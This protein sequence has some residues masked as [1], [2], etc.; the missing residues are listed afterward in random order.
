MPKVG[1]W[2]SY[3]YFSR[4]DKTIEMPHKI[5]KI[6]T[7]A[8]G[9]FLTVII[10]VSFL[11][12]CSQPADE[13]TQWNVYGGGPEGIRYS[14]L[15]QIDTNNVAQLQPVWEFHSGDAD[16]VNHSQIQCNPIIIDTVL[17]GTTPQQKLFAINAKTGKELWR[18]DPVENFKKDAGHFILNNTR[19]ICIWQEGNDKRIFFTAGS[20]LHAIDAQTGKLITPF[21]NKGKVDLHEGLGRDVKDLFI[22]YTSPGTIYKNLIIMGSRVSEDADAAPGHIRAY[23]TKTGKQVWIFHTIPQ[24]GEPGFET[25]DD[26]NA[27]KHI[28]GANCWSGFTLDEKRGTVFA[29]TGSAS[30]DFYG[31]MR[32]GANLYADCILALDAATGKL[33]WHYQYVHHDVWDKDLPTPPALVTVKRNGKD[34]DAVA[35]PTKTGTVFVLDRETGKPLF[36]IEER[37]VNTQTELTGEKL[38][39]TQPFPILP[40]PFARQDF[41]DSDVNDLIDTSEQRTIKA[42]LAQLDRGHIFTPPGKRGTVIFPGYD[43][44]AEWGGPAY[45]P[46]TGLLYV[47]ANEMPWILKL[48]D[49]KLPSEHETL[50]DAGK[51]LFT[52]NCMSCHGKNR[53][54][55]G[56]Y[57]SLLNVKDKYTVDQFLTLIQSGRRMMPSFQQLSAEERAAIASFILDIKKDQSKTF[58][59]P[60]AIDTF[61]QLAY[62]GTGYNKFLTKDGWPAIKPPWG[63]LS[64]IDLNSGAIAWKIPLG[65]IAKFKE[66]GII[67]G[68]ENYGGPVVTAGGLVFIAA[69]SDSKI[70]AF[71][72]RTGQL[73][74]EAKLPACGFATPAVYSVEG[75]QYIV[76]ACGGGKLGRA[77]GDSY[78]AFGLP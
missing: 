12:S 21:G 65:E 35:Q 58:V 33:K 42:Q 20:F 34:I 41:N 17:Y 9:V 18:F 72:K 19:G 28:G 27:W 10:T 78:I 23:D 43:G 38:Y 1:N 67:T 76:I 25:W 57:P 49:V 68:T 13:N 30:Y 62:K 74:W 2:K 59:A 77:S 71:N 60:H 73:L 63:T 31:G 70:R 3:F 7:G 53:E 8:M 69:T 45:D 29:S 26:P 4:I 15:T 14:S 32:K 5:S 52:N 24:P 61:M 75:K 56:N 46:Q 50:L 11:I 55:G 66:R 6:G 47:N 51:R 64:A 48:V 36:P 39:P 16:T 22:T 37:A 54:G 40:K 44:G